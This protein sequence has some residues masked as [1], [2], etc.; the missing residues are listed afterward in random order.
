MG[1]RSLISNTYQSIVEAV[2]GDDTDKLISTLGSDP[3]IAADVL[4][5]ARGR[6]AWSFDKAD[7]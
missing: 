1:I 3:D 7:T 6:E 2:R 5:P 4:P